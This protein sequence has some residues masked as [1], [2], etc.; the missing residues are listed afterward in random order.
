MVYKLRII[1]TWKQTVVSAG[2]Q[3]NKQ[4]KNYQKYLLEELRVMNRGVVG[5]SYAGFLRARKNDRTCFKALAPSAAV[6]LAVSA[7]VA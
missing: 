4:L 5:Q 6:L 1:Y 7:V 3:H 2:A